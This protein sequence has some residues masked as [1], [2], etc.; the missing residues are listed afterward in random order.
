MLSLLIVICIMFEMQAKRSGRSQ[1]QK[2]QS[3]SNKHLSVKDPSKIVSTSEK[4]TVKIH[5]QQKI[6]VVEQSKT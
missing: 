5:P 6:V 4:R 3:N 2:K 1:R